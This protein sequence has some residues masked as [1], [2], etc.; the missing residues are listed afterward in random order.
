MNTIQLNLSNVQAKNLFSGQTIQIKANDIGHGQAFIFST[1]NSNKI[2]KAMDKGTGVR[3]NFTQGEMR[4]NKRSI[5]GSGFGDT[6]RKAKN[7]VKKIQKNSDKITKGIARADKI[8]GKIDHYMDIAD[9]IL[10]NVPVAGQAY[11]ALHTGVSGVH[12]ATS[13]ARRVSNTTNKVIQNPSIKGAIAAGDSYDQE[14]QNYKG[15]QGGSY[16][17]YMPR[18]PKGGSFRPMG[19]SFRA[20]SGGSIRTYDDSRNRVDPNHNSWNPIPPPRYRP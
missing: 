19:G 2:M 5:D 7:T 17:P 3:V 12:D 20:M 14:Y 4:E 9:P 13:M 16:N 8:V 1:R 6:F 10:S 18:L 15:T 11:T